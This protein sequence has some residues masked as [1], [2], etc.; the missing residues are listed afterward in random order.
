MRHDAIEEE[1]ISSNLEVIFGKIEII[2]NGDRR[3]DRKKQ[4]L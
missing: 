2:F 1:K 3:T 4:G